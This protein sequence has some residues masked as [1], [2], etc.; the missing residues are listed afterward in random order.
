MSWGEYRHQSDDGLNLYA[1]V[2]PGPSVAAPVVVCLHGLLRNS[3]D[4]ED[5]APHLATRYRVIV[6][7]IRGRGLS[8]RDA[9]SANYQIPVYV[10]DLLQL[11]TG[12]GATA[13]SMVGTSMGG[14]I[15]MVMAVTHPGLISRIVLNDVGPEV[16]PVGLARIRAYAGRSAAVR[17]WDEATVELRRIYGTAWP[18]LSNQR[19]QQLGRRAYRADAKGM[20]LADADPAIGDVIRNA[21]STVPDLWPLWRALQPVPVLVFRG[22]HSDVL[23][24]EALARMH[25]EKP[26]LRSVMVRN[27][28]HVPLLDEPETLVAIDA[29]LAD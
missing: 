9:N 6:P 7:D 2:F 17:T 18:G 8:D 20:L 4:F 29:F 24:A 10:R 27:R 16:D 11:F 5:L 22:E 13:I 28:G 15:A 23:S 3:R 12:L 21:P 26:D 14:L 25:R 19:W 1:R